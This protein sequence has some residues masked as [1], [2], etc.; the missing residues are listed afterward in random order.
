M[1]KKWSGEVCDICGKEFTEQDDVAICPECGAPY[2]RACIAET[3]ACVHTELHEAGKVWESK[4]NNEQPKA[5]GVLCPRC[6]KMNTEGSHFCSGC[7]LPLGGASQEDEPMP[8]M[9]SFQAG[10]PFAE[11]KAISFETFIKNSQYGGLNPQ[12]QVAEDVTAKEAAAYVKKNPAYFLPR[13][14]LMKDR[15]LTLNFPAMLFGG[16]YYIYRKVY[17]A[18][19]LLLALQVLLSVP[20]FIVGLS[21]AA[22]MMGMTVPFAFDMNMIAN[23]DMGC[24]FVRMAIMFASGFFF[25]PLYRSHVTAKVKKYKAKYTD[26]KERLQRLSVAGGVNFGLVAVLLVAYFCVYYGV[27]MLMMSGVI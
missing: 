22:E 24:S 16:L 12:D 27:V 2:H 19:I 17:G 21:Y 15:A 5:Q 7:G 3:K 20:A 10:N 13:F 6:H 18:G 9:H 4:K 23:I 14:K 25:N 1:E 8:G 11:G 26:E